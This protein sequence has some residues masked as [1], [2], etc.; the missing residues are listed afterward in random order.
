MGQAAEARSQTNAHP[1]TPQPVEIEALPADLPLDR[2]A[3]LTVAER[4]HVALLVGPAAAATFAIIHNLTIT[5]DGQQWRT[6]TTAEIAAVACRPEGTTRRHLLKL[7]DAGLVRSTSQ[8][9]H[10]QFELDPLVDLEPVD[11]AADLPLDRWAKLT[12]AERHQLTMMVG[13]AAAWTFETALNL[14]GTADSD[15]WAWTQASNAQIAE[16]SG[17]SEGHTRR[18]L[19]SLYRHALL[20][21]TATNGGRLLKPGPA[22]ENLTTLAHSR[23][24]AR[25]LARPARGPITRDLDSYKTSTRSHLRVVSDELL[26]SELESQPLSK[27]CKVP[28]CHFPVGMRK[29]QYMPYCNGHGVG[30]WTGLPPED[31]RSPHSSRFKP[32]HRR[33]EPVQKG[34]GPDDD[35]N[36]S[37]PDWSQMTP[38]EEWAIPQAQ[39]SDTPP[40]PAAEPDPGAGSDDPDDDTP[41]AVPQFVKDQLAELRR[42]AP[43]SHSYRQRPKPV[44]DLDEPDEPRPQKFTDPILH[45]QPPD[46]DK[47]TK[48]DEPPLQKFTDPV[49]HEQPPPPQPPPQPPRSLRAR[50]RHTRAK[51]RLPRRR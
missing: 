19:T 1:H 28:D 31:P 47:P 48:P 50:T 8:S 7:Y 22:F 32:V 33:I 27:W 46:V 18:H 25:A 16:L 35:A 42:M 3:K 26:Q 14:M 45:E 29:H 39:A 6:P 13:H 9:R 15:W 37:E 36:E 24:S 21:S 17:Y 10:R 23:A 40:Q 5:I 30:D 41:G 20:H 49:L 43:S 2:W 51:R 38:G 11:A 4:H 34:I 44:K 12:I